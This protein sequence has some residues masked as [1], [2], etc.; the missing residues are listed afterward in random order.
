MGSKTLVVVLVG[1]ALL[2]ALS[3]FRVQE[4]QTALK[5]QL[6]RVERTDYAPGL[7]FKMPLIEDVLKFDKRIQTLDSAPQLYLTNEKKNVLVDSFV[8]WRISNPELFYTAVGGSVGRANDRLSVVVQKRL[9]DEI[10]KRTLQQ[11]VSGERGEIMDTLRLSARQQADQLG[12]EIV[13][14]RIKRVDLPDDVS[15]SVF[16]RMASERQQVAKLFRS[17]GEEQ[18][19]KIRA[20]AERDREVIVAEAERESLKIRGD[21][22]AR[23]PQPGGVPEQL[24]LGERRAADRAGQQVLPVLQ[25]RCRR[26][27]GA[28]A[29]CAGGPG[30]PWP[31]TGSAGHVAGPVGRSR[32]GARHRG[33]APVPESGGLPPNAAGGGAGSG[34]GPALRRPHGH[35]ARMPAA[36]RG[37]LRVRA[38]RVACVDERVGGVTLPAARIDARQVPRE[39]PPRWLVAERDGAAA[40]PAA[41]GRTAPALRD[42]VLTPRGAGGWVVCSPRGE[43]ERV[44]G[45]RRR[46]VQRNGEWT[47]VEIDGEKPRT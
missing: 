28:L 42:G 17:E 22:D 8:K 25:G 32:A 39:E 1:L 46:P 47:V 21:G 35:G 30:R 24:R 43:G 18:A 34:R 7:H 6:G 31:T 38:G 45:C 15:Q 14:A 26:R 16:D 29:R 40:L 13:D 41:S 23:L 4:T 33:C 27:A 9:K 44:A 3:V 5:L 19:R 2:A 36:L 12:I 10:G 20:E 37:A 11:V